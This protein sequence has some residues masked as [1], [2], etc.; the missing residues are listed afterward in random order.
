MNIYDAQKV[1]AGDIKFCKK[2]VI[3][4][5]RPRI[6]FNDSGICNACEY[7]EY[8]KNKI[9]WDKRENELINFELSNS[10]QILWLFKP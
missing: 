7:A 5:K 3:S 8:K 6:E 2:C 9:D 4:N 1:K 10:G